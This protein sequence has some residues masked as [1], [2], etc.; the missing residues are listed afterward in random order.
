MIDNL[1][2]KIAQF[3]LICLLEG[4]TLLILIF[5][6]VPLKYYFGNPI[7]SKIFGPIHGL[8]FIAYVGYT[9]HF[10]I[11]H[12]WSFKKIFFVSAASFFPFATFYVEKRVLAKIPA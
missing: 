5:I 7:V 3:R 12:N 11:N 1:K 9:I 6:A 4:I 8:L 10:A 2:T